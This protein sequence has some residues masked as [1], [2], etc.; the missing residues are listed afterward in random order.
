MNEI[1][2]VFIVSG[3]AFAQGSL[4]V[5]VTLAAL[6][7][8]DSAESYMYGKLKY[9]TSVTKSIGL[10][11]FCVLFLVFFIMYLIFFWYF[12]IMWKR[13]LLDHL[14]SADNN[15]RNYLPLAWGVFAFLGLISVA[16]WIHRRSKKM[17]DEIEFELDKLDKKERSLP[18]LVEFADYND[19]FGFILDRKAWNNKQVAELRNKFDRVELSYDRV[20]EVVKKYHLDVYQ[21]PVVFFL[22]K[23]RSRVSI[24]G[25]EVFSGE[26][27]TSP[28]RYASLLQKVL[29]K[30]SS[31][32][33]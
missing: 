10:T 11:V 17:P 13:A 26:D 16:T 4:L 28:E 5:F 3:G 7:G 6:F 2:A 9:D 23:D 25:N 27:L 22:D 18:V 12:P 14:L 24:D 21:P 32:G 8:K 1:L 30:F 31:E 20:P 33:A 29:E 19:F 15:I